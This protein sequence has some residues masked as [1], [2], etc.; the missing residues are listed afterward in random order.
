[1][2]NRTTDRACSFVPRTFVTVV[3]F[4]LAASSAN[5]LELDWSGQFR[6]EVNSVFDYTMDTAGANKP[7]ST[8]GYTIPG[9]GSTNAI[10]QNVFL[11][12]RPKLVVN[13]NV[14]I[15]SEWW[16]SDPIYG[17][18]GNSV[19]YTSDQRFFFSSQ[20]RGSVITAQRFWAE[21]LTDIGTFQVGRA[22]LHWGLGIVW[23]SGDGIW[24]RYMSTGDLV[25]WVAKFGAFS[26]TPAIIIYSSG[27]SIGGNCFVPTTGGPVTTCSTAGGTGFIAD[28]SLALKYENADEEFDAGVN[29]IVRRSGTTPDPGS[30][31]LTPGATVSSGGLINTTMFDLFAQKKFFNRLT[32]GAEVPIVSGGIGSYPY[33]TVAAATE[34]KWA[35]SD[36]LETLLKVGYAPGQA[37]FVAP[38]NTDTFKAFYFNPGY[39]IGMIMFRYQLANFAGPQTQNSP[40]LLPNALQSPYFNPVVNAIY[41]A[42]GGAWRVTDKWTLRPGIIYAMA[43][44]T[45]K[46]GEFAYNYRTGAVPA[47]PAPKDQG[48]QLG[49]EADLG[50][51]FQWDES[52]QVG[53]DLG[54]FLPGSFWAYS[55][56][57]TD[58]PTS[59]VLGATIKAGIS[60]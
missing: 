37:G 42:A 8:D 51:G 3:A 56:T 39:N 11:R 12:V 31:F 24:D 36:S 1:L 47:T 4:F 19:P 34:V 27:N 40:Y 45:A 53:L 17:I 32:L 48:N 60:F 43:P 35:L 23:N 33:Q 58:N 9:G 29:L 15:K 22:P 7:G 6:A 41:A 50:L 38:T 28:Y 30:S 16:L 21:F 5:A 49:W 26:V 55:G 54:I 2:K 57:L 46:T 20:S 14:Y 59:P 44:S 13:D 10:W 18:F 25:R 52:F